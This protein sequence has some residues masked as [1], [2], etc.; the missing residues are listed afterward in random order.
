M[1]TCTRVAFGRMLV[2]GSRAMSTGRVPGPSGDR[3][4]QLAGRR[5]PEPDQG[6]AGRRDGEDQRRRRSVADRC[7]GDG[8]AE[9]PGS[10]AGRGDAPA[11]REP[12]SAGAT[13]RSLDDVAGHLP[14]VTRG[15]GLPAD[16]R[17]GPHPGSVA[18]PIAAGEAPADGRTG[19]RAGLAVA[20]AGA[21]LSTP[22]GP[23]P[24]M[25][26]AARRAGSRDEPP[27]AVAPGRGERLCRAIAEGREPLPQGFDSVADFRLFLR[28]AGLSQPA[29]EVATMGRL[30]GMDRA[31]VRVLLAR[32]GPRFAIGR[33]GRPSDQ[34]RPE[35]RPGDPAFEDLA[36]LAQRD[37]PIPNPLLGRLV[38][39]DRGQVAALLELHLPQAMGRASEPG[40][41]LSMARLRAL[42]T[43]APALALDHMALLLSA[44]RREVSQ[45]L[46]AHLPEYV[47]LVVP[48]VRVDRLPGL[49]EVLVTGSVSQAGP[50]PLVRLEQTTFD[51]HGPALYT[52]QVTR[53]SGR[54]LDSEGV[55]RLQ[56][57]LAAEPGRLTVARAAQVLRVPARVVRRHLARLLPE[58]VIP[59]NAE[60]PIRQL[61]RP[62]DYG[63]L[64]L[65]EY[66][67]RYLPAGSPIHGEAIPAGQGALSAPAAD[68]PD[69]GPEA[70][71]GAEGKRRRTRGGRRPQR[72]GPP[73]EPGDVYRPGL[74]EELLALA[75]RPPLLL[76]ELVDHLDESETTLRQHL[77]RGGLE[78]LWQYGF[79]FL[80]LPPASIRR[81]RRLAAEV[82]PTKPRRMR[83][84]VRELAREMGLPPDRVYSMLH[85]YCPEY[86]FLAQP[87]WAGA[88][89]GGMFVPE[90]KVPALLAAVTGHGRPV[91]LHQVAAD[92]GCTLPQVVNSLRARQG[93][94]FRAPM[95]AH[96]PCAHAF[97]VS[98]VLAAN[99]GIGMK[100]AS[101]LAHT[102]LHRLRQCQPYL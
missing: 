75:L 21:T 65:A 15:G 10:T 61:T 23:S 84:T 99:P 90:R 32:Y 56:E 18:A 96:H 70:G 7:G 2:V 40:G 36:T 64:T 60:Q 55:A 31:S 57:L 83:Y 44:P 48:R 42:C 95:Y 50:S 77:G 8:A 82:H 100:Q 24:G 29:V 45:A 80:E 22:D 46:A 35:V 9:R 71:P 5:R 92:L 62:A 25:G 12:P 14:G 81:L 76:A 74:P 33:P 30:L 37:P 20:N 19:P 73:P 52:E 34:A 58:A 41:R 94:A 63:R 79:R 78:G 66:A 27:R 91:L 86:F 97:E 28:L 39:L 13:P 87:P 72:P 53:L 102:T 67:R 98:R 26:G 3:W 43:V 68:Q 47:D 59:H 6:A 88:G 4:S 93:D 16:R 101:E 54:D 69:H 49:R 11:D 51:A 89:P 38:G 85:R 1:L 17:P